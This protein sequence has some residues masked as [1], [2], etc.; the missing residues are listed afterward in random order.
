VYSDVDV[1]LE[2]SLDT[3][4][5]PSMSF[6]IPRD[7]IA[8]YADENFCLWNGLMG[9]AP[10]H[11]FLV[12]VVER[13]VNM[14]LDRADIY[15][16]EKDL[17]YRSPSYRSMELW[18]ARVSP[19]LMLSGPCGLGMSVNEILGG[20]TLAKYNPGW[21]PPQSQNSRFGLGPGGDALILLV[22]ATT[23]QDALAK[24][25]ISSPY[26][27]FDSLLLLR[28]TS[29]STVSYDSPTLIGTFLWPLHAY[30]D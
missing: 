14:I 8:E 2:T 17:V 16:M 18:K 5:T 26:N 11:P 9:A 15:D 27:A 28:R 21:L 1:R 10:G 4:I 23:P 20:D 13:L 22:S 3:F 29:Q 30:T 7:V 25:K 12:R 24:I 19:Q 6:F